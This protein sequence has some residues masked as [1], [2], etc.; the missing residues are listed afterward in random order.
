MDNDNVNNTGEVAPA[1]VPKAVDEVKPE[2]QKPVDETTPAEP[3]PEKK[4]DAAA[5]R[6]DFVRSSKRR[7]RHK[8]SPLWSLLKLIIALV[9][10]AV[11][12]FAILYIVAIAAKY[13]TIRAMLDSMMVELELMWQRIRN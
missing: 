10:I 13:D 9:V 7:K 4:D 3:M 5:L 6:D 1:E 8:R 2:E 11:G 12:I